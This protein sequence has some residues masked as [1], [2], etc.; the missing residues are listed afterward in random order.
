MTDTI[1]GHRE[2]T[3][4]QITAVNAVK[5]ASRKF[6][7]DIRHIFKG[8]EDGVHEGYDERWKSIARTH[9]QEGTMAAVRAIMRPDD[10]Y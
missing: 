3:E 10:D 7:D 6:Q 5:Q 4:V 8:V 1:M 9:F 2:P